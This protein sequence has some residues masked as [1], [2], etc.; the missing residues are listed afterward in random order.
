MKNLKQLITIPL[1]VFILALVS[2][3]C[4]L[5]ETGNDESKPLRLGNNSF[6]QPLVNN[7]NHYSQPNVSNVPYWQTTAAE[8]NMEFMETN[9]GTYMSGYTLVPRKRKTGC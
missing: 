4:A 3:V 8:K 6:E 5:A 7:G 1:A 2:G 9:N